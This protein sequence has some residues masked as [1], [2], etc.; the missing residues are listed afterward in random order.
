MAYVEPSV[1]ITLTWLPKSKSWRLDWRYPTPNSR[2]V[3]CGHAHVKVTAPMDSVNVARLTHA[4][5]A[6]ME[7]WL[8]FG[9]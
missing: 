8:D 3:R 4:L 9:E 5:E 2:A 6:E 7:R 1:T